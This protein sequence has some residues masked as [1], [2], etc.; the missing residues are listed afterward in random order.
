MFAHYLAGPITELLGFSELRDFATSRGQRLSFYLSPLR[1]WEILTG[2]IIAIN[3]GKPGSGGKKVS[4]VWPTIGILTIL[5]CAVFFRDASQFPGLPSLLPVL[6]T[7][8]VITTSPRTSM[9]RFLSSSPLAKLGDI[10]YS[11]YLWHWPVMVILRRIV[12]DLWVNALIS[13]PLSCLLAIVSTSHWENRFRFGSSK[14]SLL[15]LPLILIALLLVGTYI[16]RQSDAFRNYLPQTESKANT[17][18]ADNGCASSPNGWETSCT[19]GDSDVSTSIYLFGDSNARSASDGFAWIA[20][21]NRWKLTVGVMSAC[22]ANFSAVQTSESCRSVNNQRLALLQEKP[23]SLVVIITHWTNYSE[24]LSYGSISQQITSL[25]VTLRV[26]QQLQIPTLIQYQIPICDYRNQLINVRFFEGSFVR[27]GQCLA[28]FREDQT[29]SVIGELV[30]QLAS[31]CDQAVC[32]VIDLSDSLCFEKCLPFRDQVNLFSDKSH[33][34]ASAS[35]LTSH[36]YE[37]VIRRL[38]AVETS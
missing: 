27:G 4:S 22:P 16:I 9:D 10:S 38:T 28:E 13:I 18:A 37:S 1:A 35:I 3:T 7:A 14:L 32:E 6:A 29:R 26:L 23:P 21:K 30:L 24:Y 11:L 20:S 33:L 15:G 31:E 36:I 5:S 19:F 25:K 34:S 17:F 12:D 8:T 2:C